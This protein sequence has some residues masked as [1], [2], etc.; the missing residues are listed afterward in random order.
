MRIELSLTRIWDTDR[1]RQRAREPH[2]ERQRGN[3][4]QRQRDQSGWWAG[5][6]PLSGCAWTTTWPLA[7]PL[8]A[9]WIH[10]PLWLVPFGQS[11]LHT[12]PPRGP[13]LAASPP[14]GSLTSYL[15]QL[16]AQRPSCQ[17][18]L[19]WIDHCN[20][21]F[22]DFY[23]TNHAFVFCSVFKVLKSQWNFFP[24]LSSGHS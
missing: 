12:G 23:N 8:V 6:L 21:G 9:S 10:T 1:K 3:R 20:N 19:L 2:T 24:S 5:G 4:R 16:F 22:I 14:L 17:G 7:T 11:D 18:C 13:G 15:R